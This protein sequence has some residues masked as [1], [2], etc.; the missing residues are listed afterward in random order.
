MSKPK[1][2]RLTKNSPVRVSLSLRK[3][4]LDALGGP[5]KAREYL[6]NYI[7]AVTFIDHTNNN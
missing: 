2:K 3:W 1:R 4:Q 7:N 5:N 6:Y